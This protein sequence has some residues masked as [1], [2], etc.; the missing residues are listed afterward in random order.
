MKK[1]LYLSLHKKNVQQD[2][3]IYRVI[4]VRQPCLLSEQRYHGDGY[5]IL[6]I[7]NKMPLEQ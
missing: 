4:S 3:K 5:V 2:F 1:V 7:F 6:N